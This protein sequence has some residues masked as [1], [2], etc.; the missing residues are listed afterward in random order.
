M[1]IIITVLLL[2]FISTA[3]SIAQENQSKHQHSRNTD[4][5]YS[6]FGPQ[7]PP[8]WK[9]Q[10]AHMQQN[11][12]GVSAFNLYRQNQRGRTIFLTLI[13]NGLDYSNQYRVQEI[14]GGV[15]LFPFNDDDRYQFDIGGTYDKIEGSSNSN[16]IIFSRFTARP[17]RALWLRAG[18]E[19]YDGHQPGHG[20]SPFIESSL[21]SY[22]AAAKYNIGLISPIAILGSGKID[23]EI[24]NRFGGG[25]FVQGPFN[26]FLFGGYI[27]SSQEEENIRTLAVGRWA[28]FRPDNYPTGM[29]VWKHRADYDFQLGGLFF[30]NRNLLVRPAAL[31]MVTGMFVSSVTLRANSQLRQRKLMT[32]ANDYENFEYSFFYV[33]LNQKINNDQNNVGFSAFQFYKLFSDVKFTIFSEPVIGLFYTEETNPVVTGFNPITHQPVLV[34]EKEKYFSYQIG[35]KVVNKFL[36]EAIHSPTREDFTIAISYLL[37]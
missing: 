21:S 33:H 36:V 22:Y 9:L 2:F 26:S 13:N 34:D 37:K 11:N 3:I 5:R 12:E 20:T 29:F 30:G 6:V 1:K 35:I 16:K 10:L 7:S 24:N 19:Y 14:S 8:E 15:I 23:G 28:P 17:T 18:F 32:I 31:G 25:A 4:P 27:G